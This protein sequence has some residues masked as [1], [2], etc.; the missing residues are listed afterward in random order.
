MDGRKLT[1]DEQYQLRRKAIEMRE[2]GYLHEDIAEATG[3]HIG[4][5]QAWW[6][7]YKEGGLP[8]ISPK[9]RGR[10]KL[11]QQGGEDEGET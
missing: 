6:K 11:G 2:Q 9:K 7:R 10:A 1:P 3:V 8:A 4:T 5:V